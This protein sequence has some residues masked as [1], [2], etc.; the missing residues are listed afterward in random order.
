MNWSSGVVPTSRIVTARRSAFLNS[1][2]TRKT[3]THST[4]TTNT[5]CQEVKQSE[6]PLVHHKLMLTLMTGSQPRAETNNKICLATLFLVIG[7]LLVVPGDS[8]AMTTS[9]HPNVLADI[10]ENEDFWAN[11]LRYVSYF[12]SVL[13]GTAYV[14]FKPILE[15]LKRPTTAILVIA[16]AAGLYY[17][18]SSTVSMML[19]VNEFT[20]E[21]SSIVTPYN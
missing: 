1:T 4:C 14:A 18:V 3:V 16:G 13:L 12:F 11:V 8:T 5:T 6:T 10:A 15:L 17:F 19:G 9:D 7:M 2:C 21:P 20:Y